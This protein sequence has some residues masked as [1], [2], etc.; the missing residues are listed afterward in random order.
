MSKKGE[1]LLEHA[2]MSISKI[3]ET[4]NKLD[5]KLIPR[6]LITSEIEVEGKIEV[7]YKC[8]FCGEIHKAI[9]TS[10]R[11]IGFC[12][13]CFKSIN[14]SNYPEDLLSYEGRIFDDYSSLIF[15]IRYTEIID[16]KE[17]DSTY[18]I[19]L[20]P[21]FEYDEGNMVKKAGYKISLKWAMYCQKDSIFFFDNPMGESSEKRK[22]SSIS[23]AIK[24]SRWSYGGGYRCPIYTEDEGSYLGLPIQT[25]RYRLESGIKAYYSTDTLDAFKYSG[26]DYLVKMATEK[27]PS[28]IN[29]RD[30]YL[31]FTGGAYR[32]YLM[33][34]MEAPVFEQLIKAGYGELVKCDLGLVDTSKNN[35]ASALKV[36]K[37]LLPLIK[38]F[39]NNG[40]YYASSK[41]REIQDYYALDK[42][43]TEDELKFFFDEAGSLSA[44]GRIIKDFGISTSD[45]IQY[46]RRCN[47]SQCIPIKHI[48]SLWYDYL[49]M[50]KD[51]GMDL[52]DRHIKYPNSLKLE[53]DRANAKYTLIKNELQEKHFNE[54]T[55]S[56]GEKYAYENDDYFI[57]APDSMTELFNEG[58][59]LSHCVGTYSNRII[60]GTSCILFIRK[61]EEP[62]KP[63]FTCEISEYG[64][65]IQVRGYCNTTNKPKSLINFLDEWKKAKCIE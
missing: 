27:M 60:S 41:I 3:E 7:K 37:S 6:V 53:H 15:S 9:L 32:M 14:I 28:E 33:R 63:Y 40:S 35:I 61:K 19:I 42:N 64:K 34:W 47:E 38:S 39:L 49:H 57:K 12:P 10:G 50:A 13:S 24:K 58:K 25:E 48:V 21:D 1:I 2:R 52:S 44:L 5:I 22:S 45:M 65:L 36:K 51:I 43:V 18:G 20:T 26:I 8:P 54:R 46:L 23:S 17:T 56:Y 16:D 59:V 4:L 29:T 31:P 11:S 62:D 55:S 30:F